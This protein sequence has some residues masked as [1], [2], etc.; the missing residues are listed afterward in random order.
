[1]TKQH[2][3]GYLEALRRIEKNFRTKETELRLAGLG[4][5]E[6]PPEIGKLKHLI[7]LDIGHGL[8]KIQ[9]DNKMQEVRNNLKYL[10][11][12]LYQLTNLRELYLYNNKLQKLSKEIGQLTKLRILSLF[13][14]Q[15]DKLPKELCQLTNLKELYVYSN[16]LNE[17]PKEIEQLTNLTKLYIHNNQLTKLPKGISHL[18]NLQML[19]L[20]GNQLNIPPEIIEKADEPKVILNYYF[21]NVYKVKKAD[22]RPL[23]EVKVMLVGQ[24][25]V[26]KTSLVRYLAHDEKRNPDER[27]THG[28]L[29]EKWNVKVTESDTNKEHDVQLNIWDFGGQDIQH[30]THQFFL[31]KRSLYLL[32]LD[33]GYDET[34]NKLDYWLKKIQIFGGGSPVF[35]AINKSDENS[36]KLAYNDLKDK[37]N[38]KGFF[39]ISCEDGRQIPELREAIKREIGN[40]K[41]VFQPIRKEW[42]AV[43]ET[44]ENIREDY[45]SIDKY[46]EICKENGITERQSQDTL[47]FLL[48]ELGVMLHFEQHETKV[49]NPEWVTRGVYK[50]VNSAAVMQNNGRLTPE[51][52]NTEL[53]ELNAE[54]SREGKAYLCYPPEKY[55]FI[56]DLM[57]EF[58]LCYRIGE[59]KD[60]FVP[61]LLPKESHFVGDW[62]E[63]DCLGFRYNFGTGLL[64][65]SI[66][67][68]F[69]VKMNRYILNNTQWQTGVLLKDKQT[70]NKALVKADVS[71]KVVTILIDGNENTRR[72][73]LR[74]I[75]EKFDDIHEDLKANKPVEEVPHYDYPNHFIKYELLLQLERQGITEQFTEIEGNLVKYDVR[76]LLNG[77]S[78]PEER[79][80]ER[81]SK[82]DK[83]L[84]KPYS[85]S[86]DESLEKESSKT[87]EQK[88]QPEIA[89][90][91]VSLFKTIATFVGAFVVIFALIGLYDYLQQQGFLSARG[92]YI[93]LIFTVVFIV[94]IATFALVHLGA[95]P[96]SLIP[97]ILK[98]TFNLISGNKQIE[99]KDEAAE[100]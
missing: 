12:E 61:A 99:N 4:L 70:D 86:I 38:I 42:F 46:R 84:E 17:L 55:V 28:I 41:D 45:I 40:L 87:P 80:T 35:I 95:I 91:K 13:G 85:G 92:F 89:K 36:L 56:T 72:E 32:V 79:E 39:D 75:R 64:H 88:G 82:E 25:R 77:V 73:F 30:Q 68:R 51:L 5:V 50:V 83:Y 62:N 47:L 19:R 66:M 16:Q 53:E 37:Y 26:G 7:G 29:R 59:T 20:D 58:E 93:S 1:M 63:K 97:D 71:N 57:K 31:S 48:H 52:L 6:L 10:P 43:K 33:A 69:I 8:T 18:M 2:S 24:G 44:L 21:K 67:S 90:G 98:P 3:E 76:R 60:F 49:L 81:R 54:L 14:N 94:I 65:E 34:R 100:N 22:T 96:A 74:I 15:L 27:S 23:K 11:K 9:D 78:T